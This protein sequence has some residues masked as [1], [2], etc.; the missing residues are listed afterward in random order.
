MTMVPS[1]RF[2]RPTCP[3]GG[4][5]SIQLSYEGSGGIFAWIANLL[6]L[7]PVRRGYRKG[8]GLVESGRNGVKSD[9]SQTLPCEQGRESIDAR[10]WAAWRLAGKQLARNCPS[11]CLQGGGWEGV[12]GLRKSSGSGRREHPYQSSPQAGRDQIVARS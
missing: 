7:S 6:L 5:R 2:E 8:A 1:R 4:D 11:P 10:M 3:L 9:P 12:R